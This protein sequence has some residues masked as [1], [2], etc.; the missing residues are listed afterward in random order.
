VTRG[1]AIAALCAV[2]TG[3]ATPSAPDEAPS[4]PGVVRPAASVPVDHLATDEL[5][6]GKDQAFGITLP[7]GLA[8][9]ERAV[10]IVTASGPFSVHALVKYFKPRL[11]GGSFREGERSATFEHVTAP[12]APADTDLMVRIAVMVGKTRVDVIAT[13]IVK[14]PVLPD[15]ESR[16][17][18]VGL[19]PNGKVLDPTHLQ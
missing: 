15:D 2:L 16:W 17:R 7:R 13:P 18:Q 6:E 14:A 10:E 4:A 1:A 3:C 11:T 8:V 9:E 19:A 5:I 12:G